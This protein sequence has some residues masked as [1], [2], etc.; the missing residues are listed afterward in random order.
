MHTECHVVH[1]DIKPDNIMMGLGEPKILEQGVQDEAHHPS[2]RKMPS[3]MAESSS[4]L[5]A[6]LAQN[7]QTP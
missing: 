7:L 3:S 2:V 1:T 5:A 4:N 6:I